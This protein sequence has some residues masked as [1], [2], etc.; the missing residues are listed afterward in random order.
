MSPICAAATQRATF[1]LQRASSFACC[2]GSFG[3]STTNA[4][5]W[6]WLKVATV[7]PPPTLLAADMPHRLAPG[8]QV[9]TSCTLRKR[10]AVLPNQLLSR[11]VCQRRIMFE[12]TFDSGDSLTGGRRGCKS[13]NQRRSD[14]GV[15]RSRHRRLAF[16][17]AAHLLP[18]QAVV[19]SRNLTTSGT[20]R[21][22]RE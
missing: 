11:I 7:L 22:A 5:V 3:K 9:P 17:N 10:R 21:L 15:D 18:A 19:R 6:Y 12:S 1:S 4:G 8:V 14:T 20:L 16:P 13:P 2:D